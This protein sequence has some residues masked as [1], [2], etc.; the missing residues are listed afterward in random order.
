MDI[1][2]R[3]ELA[4]SIGEKQSPTL[5][6]VDIWLDSV[7]LT[8]FDNTVYLP[9]F[10]NSLKSELTDIENDDID[11]SYIFFNH[12]PTTDDVVARAT[13]N[14]GYIHLSCILN[15]GEKVE[16][17]LS[18]GVVISTYKKCISALAT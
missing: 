10:L 7:L 9:G 2:L 12:G 14:E 17:E 13:L 11:D 3:G 15:S 16:K 8:Y 18:L 6:N 4:F 5:Q 1:G